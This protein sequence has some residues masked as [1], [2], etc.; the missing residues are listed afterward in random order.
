MTDQYEEQDVELVGDEEISEA[1]AHDPK[2]AEQQ[3][4]DSVD[5]ADDMVK[6]VAKRPLDKRN[7]EP[8]P[9]TKAGI[10][11]AMY[12]KMSGMKKDEMVKMY[13]QVMHG[14][15]DKVKKEEVEA[16]V[17]NYDFNEDLNA[18]VA[19]EATLSEEFKEKASVIFDAAIKHKLS[20][21]IERLEENYANELAEELDRT[22]EDLVEKIDGYLNYVVE[23]W[24]EENKI[25]IQTGLRTEI[26]E[27]FMTNL[28]NL[29][30]ESYIEVPESKV[31]LV[32]GL[33]EQV[34]ELETALNEQTSKMISI[35]EELDLFK[36]YEVIREASRDLAQTEIEKLTSLVRDI[37]FEDE[38]TFASKVKTIKESYFKKEEVKGLSLES[39]D[40]VEETEVSD[41]MSQYINAL[42]KASK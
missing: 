22:K 41:Q 18:L 26:A 8:M 33:A 5:K 35:T 15:D 24:M 42:R 16:E 29:F 25:A 7:P 17:S 21:E 20:E 10:I 9:K 39:S 3:S 13:A 11:Q 23:Q 38:E 28:K 27:N 37:D 19:N 1:E 31:D 12:N 32:D 14:K 30:E 4:I 40:D 36:R 6:Q 2:N 34:E